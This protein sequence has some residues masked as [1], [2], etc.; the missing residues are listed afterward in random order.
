MR[1]SF[2][3]ICLAA[4]LLAGCASFPQPGQFNTSV[5]NTVQ[6]VNIAATGAVSIVTDIVKA[7]LAI[8]QPITSVLATI[9]VNP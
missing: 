3:G 1:N 2:I 4:S 8:G 5:N 9:G 7:V 6:D